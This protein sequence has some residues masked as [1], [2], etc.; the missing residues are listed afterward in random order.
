VK[1][2]FALLLVLVF[3]AGNIS[4]AQIINND[5]S[6]SKR[7][8]DLHLKSDI[9]KTTL[10]GGLG[11]NAGLAFMESNTGLAVGVFAELEAGS[12]SFVP[13]ANYWQVKKDNNFELAAIMRLK[14]A[15]TNIEPFVDGGIGINF[16]SSEKNSFTKIG[17]DVGG[18]VVL[19]T[20]S[21]DFNLV[22]DGKYKIIINNDDPGNI[23]G[24]TVTA[25]LR[26]P[27]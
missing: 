26:F 8:R 22:I 17:V 18:G 19:K 21:K 10:K 20:I 12:F 2:I 16:Y 13:Q 25:G 14:F 1:N 7:N 15:S 23:S 4:F 6:L 9:S 3:F 24:Y 27:I 5:L 11:V